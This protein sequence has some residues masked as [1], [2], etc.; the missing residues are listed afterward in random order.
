MYNIS[1]Y[2]NGF[3][4]RDYNKGEDKYERFGYISS[5]DGDTLA[6]VKQA[7][8][9]SFIVL[10]TNSFVHAEHVNGHVPFTANLNA[11]NVGFRV[12]QLENL[13]KSRHYSPMAC[14]FKSEVNFELKHSYFAGLHRALEY[15]P[16]HVIQKLIPTKEVLSSCGS[17]EYDYKVHQTSYESIKLD[18]KVQMRALYVIL[19]SSPAL[20]VLVAGPFGTGK[21]R[22]L[23]RA[24][25]EILKKR[26]SRVLICAHHQAST[27]TFVEY[28]GELKTDENEPW[29][30]NILRVTT[31]DSY[32]SETRDKYSGLFKSK[33]NLTPNDLE[34][35][36]LVITTLGTAP[37]L[38][39]N[40]PNGG[41]FTDILIDE[42]AQTREPETVGPLNLAGP[43]TRIVIAGDHCQVRL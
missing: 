31:S 30:V 9:G 21:T 26:R 41:F 32:K 20:P 43:D 34:R 10:D 24:A 3:V 19:K 14:N 40:L 12:E 4:P 28:F 2:Q 35:N 29:D 27:D 42:G 25:Y 1:L 6:H 17:K 13:K 39:H 8:Q 38:F 11:I 33:T 37:S 23:V 15:L 22:L 7:C 18:Q 36:R 5:D 16:K